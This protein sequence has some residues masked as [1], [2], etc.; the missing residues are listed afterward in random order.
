MIH[1]DK[2]LLKINE[3]FKELRL[4]SKD[5]PKQDQNQNLNKS[6]GNKSKSIFPKKDEIQVNLMN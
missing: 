5:T 2:K 3:K 4:L 6:L 1:K